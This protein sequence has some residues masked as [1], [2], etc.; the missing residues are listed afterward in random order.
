[1]FFFWGLVMPEFCFCLSGRGVAR[2]C[3]DWRVSFWA[4]KPAGK[5]AQGAETEVDDSAATQVSKD[6]GGAS[7]MEQ[8]DAGGEAGPPSPVPPSAARQAAGQAEPATFDPA[9]ADT[10]PLDEHWDSDLPAPSAGMPPASCGSA[11]APGS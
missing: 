5:R 6:E 1:M 10:L 11:H 4:E 3:P 9:L 7:D 2:S 8:S